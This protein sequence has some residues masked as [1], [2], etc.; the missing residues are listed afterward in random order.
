[1]LD[2]IVKDHAGHF[3]GDLGQGAFTVYDDGQPQAISLFT[4]ED[5]PATIGLVVD[6]SVSMWNI[7]DRVLESALRFA[8]AGRPSDELFAL[9]FNDRVVPAL[10]AD[11]PFTSSPGV[12]QAAL[13]SVFNTRGRTALFDATA[14]GLEYA[15]RGEH[16][17]KVLVVITDCGDNISRLTGAEVVAKAQAS[18]AVIYPVLLKDP[19]D[20]AN[21]LHLLERL[22]DASGGQVFTPSS[23]QELTAALHVVAEDVRHAYTIGYVPA[24]AGEPRMHRVNVTVAEPGRRLTAR[25]RTGYQSGPW[26]GNHGPDR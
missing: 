5:V 15:A 21:N 8:S 25:T 16:L 18:D 6:S 3:V 24:Q 9:V 12:L 23:P 19:D 26:S 14:A 10:P 13:A 1:M 22:A 20:R 7:R 11:A 2:V 4:N 17:R